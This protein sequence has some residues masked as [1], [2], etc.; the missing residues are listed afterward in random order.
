V[1]PRESII[2]AKEAFLDAVRYPLP[3]VVE[4]SGYF[5]DSLKVRVLGSLAEPG[6]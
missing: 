3:T 4:V 6:T 2:S 5:P 1:V